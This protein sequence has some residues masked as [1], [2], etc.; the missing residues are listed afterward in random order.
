MASLKN[1]S[2]NM[3]IGY[4]QIGTKTQLYI[5]VGQERQYYGTLKSGKGDKF[6]KMIQRW[7]EAV[8]EMME[9]KYEQDQDGFGHRKMDSR[10]GTE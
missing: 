3:E 9:E 6:L 2:A 7:A 4:V 5:Q 1:S 8:A 10:Q